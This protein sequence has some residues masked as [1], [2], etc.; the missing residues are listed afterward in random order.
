M[1][2]NAAVAGQFYPGDPT[3]LREMLSQLIPLKAVKQDAIGVLLPHAGYIYS[4]KVVGAV[5]SRINIK[6][7]AIIIGPNHTGRGKAYSIMTESTWT[8]PLGEI[9][10][11]T[12][13]AKAI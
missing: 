3:K 1:I 6:D 5:L 9:Q 10:I 8:T 4:G 11:D 13:L 12:Q 7:T 2:R